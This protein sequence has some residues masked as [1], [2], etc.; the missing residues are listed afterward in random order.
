MSEYSSD[1]EMFSVGPKIR[2]SV[3]SPRCSGV[4]TNASSG[5][6]L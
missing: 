6:S 2:C 3:S 1:S 5:R 4:A